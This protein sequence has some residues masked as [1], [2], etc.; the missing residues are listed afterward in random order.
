MFALQWKCI[1]L[2]HILTKND[3]TSML[4]HSHRQNMPEMQNI[5]WNCQPQPFV[6]ATAAEHT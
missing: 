2:S 1:E 5:L 3:T 6:G 4:G